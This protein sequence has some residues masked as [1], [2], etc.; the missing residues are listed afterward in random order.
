MCRDDLKEYNNNYKNYEKIFK[1]FITILE[2]NTILKLNI[3]I[4]IES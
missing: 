3:L 2:L 1:I 4:F